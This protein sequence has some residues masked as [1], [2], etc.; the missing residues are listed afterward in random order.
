MSLSIKRRAEEFVA[1]YGDKAE[2]VV[3]EIIFSFPKWLTVNQMA[4]EYFIEVKK[5]IQDI[6]GNNSKS[7]A[8]PSQK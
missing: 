6:C 1:K 3:D 7:D 2:D 5:Q 4:I 8:H